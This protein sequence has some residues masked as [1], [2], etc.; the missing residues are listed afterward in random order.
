M[1]FK[2]SIK[3]LADKVILLK[4]GIQTEEA[5]LLTINY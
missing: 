5:T 2:D 1:D 4:D 3:Q